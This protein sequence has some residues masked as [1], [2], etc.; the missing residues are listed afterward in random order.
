MAERESPIDPAPAV[1]A[2]L[3]A[4]GRAVA[5]D[6]FDTLLWRRTLSPADAFALLPHGRFGNA[7]RPR[8][9]AVVTAVCRRL[10][11]REP[12]L[13]DI[14]GR[15]YYPFDRAA[16]LALEAR[17][18]VAN[19]FCL[20]LVRRLVDRDVPVVAVS[21]MYLSG[22]QIAALLQGVGYPTL[23]VLS[24]ADAGVSKRVDGGLFA[25][26]V[27]VLGAPPA[28]VL[29]VG[30][31]W[32]ADIAMAQRRGLASQRL[33]TPRETLLALRPELERAPPRGQ[34]AL[35]WGE[36]ALAVHG[37]PALG[38]QDLAALKTGLA[39]L[40]NQPGARQR[41]PQ[42]LADALFHPQETPP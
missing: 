32:H 39:R 23:A 21:D 37:H 6:V 14:Y 42:A 8:V 35:F 16:E 19:P 3:A 34:D 30:D 1:E 9:E 22:A 41:T 17:L 29:H 38:A 7:L 33:R 27:Q 5:F 20:A 15:F 4:G 12:R 13:D 26:A 31:D 40:L 2:F 11:R 24:S 10:L 28:G 36:L 18:V 25:H